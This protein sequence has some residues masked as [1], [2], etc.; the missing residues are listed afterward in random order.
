MT[1][2]AGALVSTFLVHGGFVDDSGWE[3]LHQIL[4]KEGYNVI[5]VQ[6]PTRSLTED[7]AFARRAIDAACRPVILVGHSYGGVVITEPGNHPKVAGLVYV[8][9]FAPDKGESVSSLI[10]N[11]APGAPVPLILAVSSRKQLILSA[12]IRAAATS[13]YAAPPAVGEAI[14][15]AT[16]PRSPPASSPLS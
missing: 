5:V 8:A 11:P 2:I 1:L 12:Q 4:K 6:N 9:A 10:A 16:A 7:V 14:S 3:G 13:L 15:E